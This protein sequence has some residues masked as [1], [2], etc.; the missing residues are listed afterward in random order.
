MKT[1]VITVSRHFPAT[2]KRKGE[3]TG[4]VEK[5]LSKEKKH[6]IRANYDL[7]VKR[8]EKI[9]KGLACLSIRYWE[10]KP[11][12]S[13]QVE[14][15]RLFDSDGIGIEKLQ[16]AN[17]MAYARIGINT[18]N[19]IHIAKN[20]GLSFVDFDEWFKNCGPEPM[21]MIHFTSFRYYRQPRPQKAQ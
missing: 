21:A 18:F 15:M 20:D 10:G 14:F 5:I 11:Y 17:N 7:W 13:K 2:H 12:Q 9:N 16:D 6:T 1:Y 8:F 4:F 3:P 19:W